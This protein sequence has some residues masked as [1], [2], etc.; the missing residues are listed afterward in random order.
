[1]AA[2]ASQ[3]RAPTE[4]KPESG[5]NEPYTYYHKSLRLWFLAYGIGAP[6]FLV[7]FPQ[8]L[9][10]LRALDLLR[11][12]T[13]LFLAGVAIQVLSAVIYKSAMW[14]LYLWELGRLPKADWRIRVSG[15]VTN[16]FWLELTFDGSTIVLYGAASW[17]TITNTT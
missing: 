3:P 15:S 9:E 1:M 4:Q 14:Y 17:L 5:Y 7:Q 11:P 10:T 12:I 16:A 8:A 2:D 6:V 13:V